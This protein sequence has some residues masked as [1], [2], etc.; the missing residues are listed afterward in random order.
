M[1]IIDAHWDTRNLGLKTAEITFD[2]EDVAIDNDA[3]AAAINEYEYCVAKTPLGCLP[4]YK[5]LSEIGFQ[6][7]ECS[8]TFEHS[9]NALP[10]RRTRHSLA[11]DEQIRCILDRIEARTGR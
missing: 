6:F 9:L 5:Q 8:I 3:I 10:E 11:T 2:K 4:L 7:A 1:Q